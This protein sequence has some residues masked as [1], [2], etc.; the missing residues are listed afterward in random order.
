MSEMDRPSMAVQ[1]PWPRRWDTRSAFD[2]KSFSRLPYL[3]SVIGL[4]IVAVVAL[5]VLQEVVWRT[6]RPPSSIF[7]QVFVALFSICL[8]ATP[9]AIAGVIGLLWT[10]KPFT[11]KRSAHRI[12]TC[13]CFRIVS[14]GQ[15]AEALRSTVRNV[16]DMMAASPAF[17]YRIEVV[18]DLPLTL[19]AGDDLVH[20][21]VPQ[22]YQTPKRAKFKARALQYAQ[23]TSDLPERAWIMHL[24]EE[25]HIT[26]L[27]V[28]VIAEAVDQEDQR[29][30]P[31]IGQGT[32]LYHR[33]LGHQPFL[34][35]ADSI[36]VGD[37]LGRFHFQHR[38]GTMLFGL[39]GS[40]ILVRNDIE[41]E[42][43]FDFGPRGSIT[44]DAFWALVQ[45]QNGHRSRWLKGHIVEQ[46]TRSVRDFIQQRRRWFIGLVLVVLY[47]PVAL[48][49]R[50]GL[51]ISVGAWSLSWVSL[52]VVIVNLVVGV[53]LPW[54]VRLA[55]NL[56]YA[57]YVVLYVIG[58]RVMLHADATRSA[59][60]CAGYYAMLVILMPVFALM[61]AAGVLYGLIRPDVGSFY[62]VKK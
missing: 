20:L 28:D 17:P 54:F 24:D 62:V 50:L 49:Y 58:L 26:P 41:K 53:E 55:G 45:M 61:E 23:E 60:R 31:R 19:D 56:I 21:L 15:N 37:D 25:S 12:D 7:D 8:V 52:L 22:D 27:L 9:S 4:F 6:S 1:E 38:I 36:R 32:I 42:V 14:R 48:R 29:W 5:Y 33:D 34:T 39:H 11:P 16:R 18:T 43:G 35:L 30:M 44:E 13:V 46:S 57:Y 3:V 2:V 40:F 47:A 59:V 51:I 10:E